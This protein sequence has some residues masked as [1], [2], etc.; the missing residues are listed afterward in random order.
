MALPESA[1]ERMQ[2]A[3]YRIFYD[4]FIKMNVQHRTLNVEHRMK[5]NGPITKIKAA[6]ALS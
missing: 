3:E 5:K 4:D 6:F 1:R 2:K